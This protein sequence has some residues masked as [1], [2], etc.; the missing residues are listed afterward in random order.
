MLRYHEYIF[1]ATAALLKYTLSK[2]VSTFDLWEVTLKLDL[3]D[4]NNL[5]IN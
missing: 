4:K 5:Q 1:G 3:Y 2:R